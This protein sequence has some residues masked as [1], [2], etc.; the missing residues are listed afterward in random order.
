MQALVQKLIGQLKAKTCNWEVEIDERGLPKI[1]K[2]TLGRR[3]RKAISLVD[4]R[5]DG[6]NYRPGSYS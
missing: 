1:E 5:D 4:I 6:L 3:K 2:G